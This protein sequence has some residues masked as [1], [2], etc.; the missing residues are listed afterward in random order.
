MT[1][2]IVSES[3]GA[4]YS[5]YIEGQIRREFKESLTKMEKYAYHKMMEALISMDVSIDGDEYEVR[6]KPVVSILLKEKPNDTK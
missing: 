1:I 3:F 6:I 4:L 2:G 5:H